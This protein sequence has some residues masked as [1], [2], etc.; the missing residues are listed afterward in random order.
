MPQKI[1]IL[2]LAK[3]AEYINN[4]LITL[5]AK[6][7]K[8]LSSSDW[9]QLIDSGLTVAN[10]LEW[11]YWRHAVRECNLD[12]RATI[13][14]NTIRLDA[15][16]GA[17]PPVKHRTDEQFKFILNDF[18][19]SSVDNFKKSCVIILLEYNSEY[20]KQ[21]IAKI[22]K[23]DTINKSYENLISLITR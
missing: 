5:K 20:S 9:T 6:Q 8:L 2:N 3:P 23:S 12:D 14:H 1:K 13:S 15:L 22:N 21:D 11:R 16:E 17:K 7:F 18:N 19:Y 4:E 10:V